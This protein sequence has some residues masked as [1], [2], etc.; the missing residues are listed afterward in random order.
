MT[1]YIF[2][3]NTEQTKEV[4]L[5]KA[6]F[7][8]DNKIALYVIENNEPTAIVYFSALRLSKLRTL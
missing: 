3:V 7:T 6:G 1:T 2:G 8:L 4:H 5:Q